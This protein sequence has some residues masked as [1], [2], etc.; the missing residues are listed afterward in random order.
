MTYKSIIVQIKDEVATLI[1]NRPAKLNALN[2]QLLKETAA[3]IKLLNEDESVKVLIMTG[4]GRGFCSG[5]DLSGDLSITDRKQPGASRAERTGPFA[6]L[7][8]GIQQMSRFTKPII[9]AVNGPAVGAGLSY[10]LAADIRIASEKATFSAIFIKRGLVPDAG[11]SFYLPRLVGISKAMELM[12]TGEII[13]AREA[14]RIGLVNRVVPH[15]E[16][17]QS[18]RDF[19]LQLAEGPSL[20]VDMVKQMARTSLK[21]DSVVTQMGIEDY[22]QRIAGESEDAIEGRTAFLEKRPTRFKGK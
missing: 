9:A 1:L 12:W 19:A 2:P 21:V 4:A 20:A 17:M 13:D 15:D 7:G 16:L 11:V 3:A 14:E 22:M 6:A 5:A 10:A 8:W 18:A